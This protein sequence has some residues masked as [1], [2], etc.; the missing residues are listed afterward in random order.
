VKIPSDVSVQFGAQPDSG[1]EPGELIEFNVTVTNNGPEV[2][3]DIS[4]ISSEFYGEIDVNSGTQNC[5]LVL[6]VGNGTDPVPSGADITTD[7]SK[8]GEPFFIYFWFPFYDGGPLE[9]GESRTCTFSRPSTSLMPPV[10]SFS[11]GLQISYFED[12]NPANDTS[13]V[14]LRRGTLP[15]QL[16]ML[17]PAAVLALLAGIVLCASLALQRRQSRRHR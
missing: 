16:P 6:A 4:L 8:G 2:V 5:T 15:T 10:W 12:L 11:F 14:T 17:T 1:I 3:G 13:T 9:V 7:A